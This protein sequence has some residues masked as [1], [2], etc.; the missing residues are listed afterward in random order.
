MVDI[1]FADNLRLLMKQN[2]LN[3]SELAKKIGVVSSAV[4]AW[5]SNKKQPSITSLWLLADYFCCTIDELVGRA[6]I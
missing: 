3:Q 1:K 2:M 6:E 5:L 4:S